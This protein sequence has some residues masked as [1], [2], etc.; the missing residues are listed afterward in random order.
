MQKKYSLAVIGHPI[1][2]SLSPTIHQTALRELGLEGSYQAIDVAP[3]QLEQFVADAKKTLNGF[4]VTVPLKEKIIPFLDQV[5]SS[6]QHVDAVNTVLIKDQKLV[7]FNTDGQGLI[8]ALNDLNKWQPHQKNILVLGAGGAAK[9][10]CHAFA[11]NKAK[12]VIISNRNLQRAQ[13]L[14]SD[15]N[16]IYSTT[17]FIAE[18]MNGV[19][20]WQKLHLIINTTSLGLDGKFFW[21]LDFAKISTKTLIAD[22]VYRPLITPFL[23]MAKSCKLATHPGW[24]MLLYQALLSFEIWTGQFP[25]INPI[26]KALL[27]KLEKK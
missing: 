3:D 13:N 27:K 16:K 5:D 24:G 21:P 8:K 1:S 25:K 4:N 10:I 15:L 19:Y 6:A 14:C 20:P 11:Q 18:K 2:H 23:H 22:I 7:G 17:Q 9:G 12:T 26:Q